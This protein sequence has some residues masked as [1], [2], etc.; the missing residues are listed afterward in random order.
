MEYKIQFMEAYNAT[1]VHFTG[2]V[3]VNDEPAI[4]A[5]VKE[6]LVPKNWKKVMFNLSQLDYIDS[7]GMGSFLT[8][9]SILNNN[10]GELVL[11]SP[12]PQIFKILMLAGFNKIFLIYDTEADAVKG[13]SQV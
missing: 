3:N 2:S 1:M 12:S 13:L 7:A 8:A 9:R 5:M 6:E 10:G 11:L 4:V